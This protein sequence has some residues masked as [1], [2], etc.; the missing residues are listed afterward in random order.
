MFGNFFKFLNEFGIIFL[1]DTHVIEEKRNEF[2]Y[3]FREFDVK[4]IDAKKVHNFGRAS[5]GCVFGYKRTLKKTLDLE[6]SE[7]LDTVVLKARF[8]NLSVVF[9]PTY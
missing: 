9:V 1:Y 7:E 4:W 3:Y 8:N 5:G 6:F 2:E